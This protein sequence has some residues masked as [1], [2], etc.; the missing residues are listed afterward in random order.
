M[1]KMNSRNRRPL[2]LNLLR[3]NATI[4]RDLL[5]LSNLIT[6][7]RLPITLPVSNH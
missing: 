3:R 6:D 4:V 1:K 5:L 2:R 7:Y